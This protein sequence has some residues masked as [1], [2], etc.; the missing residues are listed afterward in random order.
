VSQYLAL[1]DVPP[2]ASIELGGR[3]YVVTQITHEPL[4][5]WLHDGLT[6]L[7]PQGGLDPDRPIKILAH[8]ATALPDFW[9]S[10]EFTGG[11]EIMSDVMLSILAAHRLG[12]T[13]LRVT[14]EAGGR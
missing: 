6:Q 1:R 8:P 12:R 3:A 13:P 5:V 2:G 4:T 7:D 9:E 11:P 14:V 10:V